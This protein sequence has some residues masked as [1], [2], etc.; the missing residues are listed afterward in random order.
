MLRNK[1]VVKQLLLS[2]V[3]YSSSHLATILGTW[4]VRFILLFCKVEIM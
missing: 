1:D 2:L 4:V 3:A